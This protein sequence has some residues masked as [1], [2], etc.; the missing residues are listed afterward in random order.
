M[1]YEHVFKSTKSAEGKCKKENG[2]KAG[3]SRGGGV[4][5]INRYSGHVRG[6]AHFVFITCPPLRGFHHS[7]NFDR[8]LK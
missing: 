6:D 2:E 8:V 1:F 4:G 5:G 3:C 7:K